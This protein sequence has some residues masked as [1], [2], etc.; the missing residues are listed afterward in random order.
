MSSSHDGPTVSEDTRNVSY[1]YGNDDKSSGSYKPLM[2]NGDPETFSWWKSKIYTHIVGIDE[3][4]WDILEDDVDLTLDE[5]GVDFDRKKHTAAQK[6]LY[7][8][9]H[10]I[11]GIIVV[12]LPHKEYLKLGDKSTAKAM[13]KSLCF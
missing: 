8:K 2:F 3:E 5:E 13:F 12:V 9:H 11:R 10:K 4:L 7:K 6:K 1:D